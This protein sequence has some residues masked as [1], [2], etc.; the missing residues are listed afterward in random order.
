MMRVVMHSAR[1]ELSTIV[2]HA[3]VPGGG[4]WEY[5]FGGGRVGQCGRVGAE[6]GVRWGGVGLGVGGVCVGGCVGGCV[7]GVYG[8]C[9]CVCMVMSVVCVWC[10]YVCVHGCECGVCMVWRSVF[11]GV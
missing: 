1:W 8:V 2:L 4:G 7:C 5:G 9:M 3:A 10:V 6:S 11:G